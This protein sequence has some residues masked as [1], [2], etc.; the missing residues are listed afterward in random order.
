M[1]NKVITIQENEDFL[2]QV[3]TSV[4][5]DDKKLKSDIE[6]LENYCKEN[7]VMAYCPYRLLPIRTVSTLS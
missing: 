4:S 6:K 5:L 2:R 7:E 1:Q 3:S